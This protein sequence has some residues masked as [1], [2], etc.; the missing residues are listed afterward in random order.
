MTS[1]SPRMTL[2]A[3]RGPDDAL[4]HSDV[5]VPARA[6]VLFAVAV[7]TGGASWRGVGTG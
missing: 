6:F 2:A 1:E 3:V 5:T 4:S 7:A